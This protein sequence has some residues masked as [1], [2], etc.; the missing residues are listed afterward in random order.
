CQ[1]AERVYILLEHDGP[2]WMVA[3]DKASGE[4]VWSPE[5]SPRRSWSSPALVDVAGAPQIVISSAGSVDRYAPASG[6]LLSPFDDVGGNTSTTPIDCGQGRF[7]TGAAAGRGEDSAPEAKYSNGMMH[8]QPTE[9][10]WKAERVWVAQDAAPSWAS[11]I[12]HQGL[13]YWINRG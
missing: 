7:L 3:L 13:A 6:E 9:D 4:T 2:S 1:T 5:R 11:P 8:I 10:G 12:V